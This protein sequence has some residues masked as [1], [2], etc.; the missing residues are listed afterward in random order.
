MASSAGGIRRLARRYVE[1]AL[2]KTIRQD[3]VG[4]SLTESV[5][6]R[7]GACAS[8]FGAGY[9]HGRFPWTLLSS[10]CRFHQLVR[11][12][13]DPIWKLTPCTQWA[14]TAEPNKVAPNNPLAEV[15]SLLGGKRLA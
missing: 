9:M 5:D 2:A 10:W 15:I 6:A 3:G 8:Y 1:F 4:L 11:H 13:F 14:E 12:N 7:P